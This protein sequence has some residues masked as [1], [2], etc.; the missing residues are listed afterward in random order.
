MAVHHGERKVQRVERG[1]P[2]PLCLPPALGALLH[3]LLQ[4]GVERLQLDVL[5]A[6]SRQFPRSVNNRRSGDGGSGR[7][8]DGGRAQA[9][10]GEKS[11]RDHG[12]DGDNFG[13]H[14][15]EDEG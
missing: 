6:Q 3:R 12:Q 9:A 10:P 8:R 7:S 5:L 11:N 14:K 2:V 13:I 1:V 15:S 4:L